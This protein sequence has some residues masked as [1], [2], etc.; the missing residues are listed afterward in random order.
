MEK[1]K[2]KSSTKPF[3]IASD[4]PGFRELSDEALDGQLS[5]ALERVAQDGEPKRTAERIASALYSEEDKREAFCLAAII[6][7]V[8]GEVSAEEDHVLEVFG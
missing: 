7:L 4:L 5:F 1:Q 2:K 6:R 3:M 8:D